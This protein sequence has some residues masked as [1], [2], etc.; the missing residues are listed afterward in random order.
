MKGNERATA[1]NKKL[2]V[3]QRQPTEWQIAFIT[4]LSEVDYYLEHTKT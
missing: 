4:V 3:E 2:S 1:Q